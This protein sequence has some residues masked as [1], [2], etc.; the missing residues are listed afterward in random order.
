M[1]NLLVSWLVLAL[2]VWVT[3]AVLPGMRVKGAGGALW[4]AALFGLLNFLIGWFFF[5]I[6]GIATLGLGFLL[7]FITRWIV[8]AILLKLT[9]AM[10]SKL[11][12]RSFGTALIAALLMAGIGSFA[13]YLIRLA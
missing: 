3:A 13:E 11:H 6:I 2:A 1:V 5:A 7:A 8:D 12:V 10:S 9:G 4:I